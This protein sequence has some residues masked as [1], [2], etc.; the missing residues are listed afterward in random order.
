LYEKITGTNI[1][2]LHEE[3]AIS[4]AWKKEELFAYF[5]K[6]VFRYAKSDLFRLI[7]AYNDSSESIRKRIQQ[8]ESDL[9]EDRQ[10]PVRKQDHLR[11]LVENFFGKYADRYDRHS[12][13]FGESYD[14]FYNNLTDAKRAISIRP[15]L[16][17]LYKAI[18]SALKEDSLENQ[19]RNPFFS[20]QVLPACYYASSE[21][22]AYSAERY[23]RDL[24][25]EQGNELLFYFS[26]YI[27][28]DGLDRF[29]IYEFT[30][31]EL[32]DLLNR[33]LTFRNYQREE[34]L[35]N[36]S[37]D[38]FKNLLINNGILRVSHVTSRR[39]T[40]YAIPFLYRNFLGV[41]N[42]RSRQNGRQSIS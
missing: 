33:I 12:N 38:D 32:D 7:Y 3:F 19:R 8:I 24:S 28:E 30:R 13:Q 40:R 27:R 21:T 34:S 14:W 42:P 18:E 10:I 37:V 20:K 2:Q 31:E 11:I 9:D 17:L 15:F 1:H 35:K 26:K 6:F 41:R 16:D 22:R 29:R 25:R 36:V 4:L 23:Y 5:F 39:L